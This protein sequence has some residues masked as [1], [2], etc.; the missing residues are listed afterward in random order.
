[1]GSCFAICGK[2]SIAMEIYV[3]KVS[4][5]DGVSHAEP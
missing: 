2:K 4:P 3:N 1:M 5:R